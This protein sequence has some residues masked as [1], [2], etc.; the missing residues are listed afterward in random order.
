MTGRIPRGATKLHA[1]ARAGPIMADRSPA[2]RTRMT[3]RLASLVAVPGAPCVGEFDSVVTVPSPASAEVEPIVSRSG[4]C[5]SDISRRRARRAA[6]PRTNFGPT[7][8]YCFVTSPAST[9]WFSTT[10]SPGGRHC[11]ARSVRSGRRVRSSVGA[12]RDRASSAPWVGP[13]NDLL[14]RLAAGAGT[15]GDAVG[16]QGR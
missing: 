11:S 5:T 16:V 1:A 8:S 7:G 6:G 10:P 14:A 4:C 2:V 9:S 13:S 15:S 3:L 12:R